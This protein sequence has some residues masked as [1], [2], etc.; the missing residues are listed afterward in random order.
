[1]LPLHKRLVLVVGVKDSYFVAS[2]SFGKD[3]LAMV[4]RLIEENKPLNEVIFY[5]TGMEF[6]C[7]YN[8]RD[9]MK[10]IFKEKGIKFT[11]LKPERPFLYDMLEK[12]VRK[13]NGET[14]LGYGWCGGACR[15]GTS[16]KITA[17]NKH[18]KTTNNVRMYVGIAIDEPER[19]EKLEPWK[20]SPLEKWKMT[21]K[22]CLQYCKA[23]GFS[24]KENDNVDL[25][26][27]LDRVSCWCCKNKNMKELKNIYK[28]FPDYWRKLVSL[29]EKIGVNMKNY[30]TDPCYGDLGNLTNLEKKFEEE[31]KQ[32]NL[33]D[34]FNQ[35]KFG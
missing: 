27:V 12:P 24:W 31:A 16:N 4:L 20:S 1:M 28:Y 9:K 5:D 33:F 15:W 17:I 21:E 19:L 10:D 14:Q 8:I 13:R 7:I 18:L 23:K 2:C 29:Q 3:S 26:D 22:D 11:E 30:K 6:Q 35:D 25:Y 32:I 34:L